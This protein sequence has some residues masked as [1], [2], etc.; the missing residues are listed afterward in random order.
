MGPTSH[1]HLENC[2][3]LSSS[4]VKT[5]ANPLIDRHSRCRQMS[6]FRSSACRHLSS[7]VVI[8]R[9]FAAGRSPGPS[10]EPSPDPKPPPEALESGRTSPRRSPTLGAGGGA[11][12]PPNGG[13]TARARSVD[14]RPPAGRRAQS[15][16]RAQGGRFHGHRLAPR[17]RANSGGVSLGSGHRVR[18]GARIVRYAGGARDRLVYP[19]RVDLRNG[20]G[21]VRCPAHCDP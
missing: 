3:H 11:I 16:R 18:G 19:K 1:R 5:A 14:C 9:H 4:V 21:N 2:R 7:K 15:G 12:N 8:C 17:T 20:V 6:S 13:G 10:P